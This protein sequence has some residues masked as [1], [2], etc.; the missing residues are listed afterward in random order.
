MYLFTERIELH[1]LYLVVHRLLIF[2]VG[3]KFYLTEEYK[4]ETLAIIIGIT[5]IT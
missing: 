5:G 2:I 1:N 4:S 3:F